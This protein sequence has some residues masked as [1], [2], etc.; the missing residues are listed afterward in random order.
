MG[1]ILVDVVLVDDIWLDVD[2]FT[3]FH[4]NKKTRKKK[5]GGHFCVPRFRK[6]TKIKKIGE[7][8]QKQWGFDFRKKHVKKK[9]RKKKR[10]G[11][12]CETRVFLLL[13]NTVYRNA[14]I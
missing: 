2:L 13:R 10:G 14:I 8:L 3:L 12:K 9:T 6:T 11:Q 7:T 4:N 1:G 5:R